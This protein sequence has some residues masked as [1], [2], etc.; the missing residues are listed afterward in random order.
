MRTRRVS[1]IVQLRR[2]IRPS[3]WGWKAVDMLSLICPHFARAVQNLLV[4]RGSLSETIF[5]DHPCRQMT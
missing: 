1:R 2:S 4:K 3:D 5:L